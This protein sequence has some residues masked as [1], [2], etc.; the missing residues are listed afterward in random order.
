MGSWRLG[1]S[2]LGA[3]WLPVSEL[4]AASAGGEWAFS[5]WPA[6]AG[7]S[8][9]TSGAARPH[10][11]HEVPMLDWDT[12]ACGVADGWDDNRT[13][14]PEIQKYCVVLCCWH[15]DSQPR[16][17]TCNRNMNLKDFGNA[18]RCSQNG[19]EKEKIQCHSFT[20]F[21][22][23]C[24]VRQMHVFG[25]DLSRADAKLPTW[26]LCGCKQGKIEG[27]LG[28][29]PWDDC[30]II[31]PCALEEPVTLLTSR[32][33]MVLAR[34]DG[35]KEP[36]SMSLPEMIPILAFKKSHLVKEGDEDA[37]GRS[38]VSNGAFLWCGSNGEMAELGLGCGPGA[39]PHSILL[40]FDHPDYG[41]GVHEVAK[42][43]LEDHLPTINEFKTYAR[44]L[45]QVDPQACAD[46]VKDAA[47][48][49]RSLR[50]ATV[51]PW[52]ARTKKIN[53]SIRMKFSEGKGV[54]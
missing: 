53:T 7:A 32:R 29:C 24:L 21:V 22:S 11:S 14:L 48:R 27:K 52:K 25:V 50:A 2:L 23:M 8:G 5:A 3:Q 1:F 15:K 37:L 51:G 42:G 35:T 4:P 31:W 33:Q 49:V 20:V 6:L 17:A 45:Q 13:R 47:E 36:G 46:F 54:L 41:F 39:S 16:L 44:K 26:S 28:F 18:C 34:V 30:T 19:A 10:R 9:A 38:I 40:K 43:S 12:N